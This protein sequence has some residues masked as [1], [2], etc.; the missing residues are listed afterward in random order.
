M[1]LVLLMSAFSYAKPSYGADLPN[2]T[3][4]VYVTNNTVPADGTSQTSVVL[5]LKDQAGQ[6]ISVAPNRIAFRATAGRLSESVTA[7][8]YG[9]YSSVLTA[10]TAAGI[11]Y[12]SA[13]VDGMVIAGPIRVNFRAGAAD[14]KQTVLSVNQTSL[15]ANGNSQTIIHVNLKDAYGNEVSEQAQSLQLF[16]SLGQI[17][18][19]T[20]DTYGQY[21]ASIV[22]A[23]YGELGS[24]T[25][26]VGLAGPFQ[27]EFK[28][29]V[30]P[31]SGSDGG[32]IPALLSMTYE[33]HGAYEA[34]LTAPSQPGKARITASLNGVSVSSSVYVTFG[35]DVQADT[36]TSLSFG[37]STYSSVVGQDV[38][39]QLKAEWRSGVSTD[40]S[41]Y[42][43]YS[44]ADPSMASVSPGG[45]LQA[46]K[47]GQTVL[48]ATYGGALTHAGITVT[49]A[50]NPAGDSGDSSDSGNSP[51]NSNPPSPGT[52][53]PE[54]SPSVPDS[55]S[56]ITIVSSDGKSRQ[57]AVS[58]EDMK[59]GS[60]EL[61]IDKAGGLVSIP[62]AVVQE[63]RASNQQ[64]QVTVRAGES[65]MT[66]PVQEMNPQTYSDQF[67]VPADSIQFQV[68]IGEPQPAV[69]DAIRMLSELTESK[70]LSSPV[71]FEIGVTGAQNQTA[72]ISSFNSY[73]TR[74]IGM[75]SQ[76]VPATATGVWWD[77]AA[78]EFHFVPTVFE[79]R[80]GQW[81]AVMK[82]QG[83][84]LF[85][86]IDHPV[87]FEDV[88]HHWAGDDVS[89]LASKLIVQGRGRE[90]FEPEAPI[91][92][93]E[94]AALL[95]RAMGMNEAGVEAPFRDN[96]GGWYENAVGA[97]YR[98][99]L[100][101]GYEDG[102]FRPEQQVTREEVAVMMVRAMQFAGL[103]PAAFEKRGVPFADQQSI[104]NW[105]QEKVQAA[106]AAGIVETGGDFRPGSLSTRAEAVTML[107][108]MLQSV[109]FISS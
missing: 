40:V 73:V 42:A 108:R 22:S 80:G 93:A 17:G 13:D 10:P 52:S 26:N 47:P 90:L 66:L 84:S 3:G 86:V 24:A 91:T 77:P 58:P 44:I 41:P 70:L 5:L 46:L 50:E 103:N 76:A 109:G 102:T 25:E 106:G 54:S 101:S 107:K 96:S 92:R 83:A 36:V 43:V 99:G 33:S 37:Q 7:S 100:V 59:K 55:T 97:A 35:G 18:S 34:V 62:A 39:T 89:L 4:Q 72:F 27:F 88:K 28:P 20:Y 79:Q 53:P 98:A 64:A 2:V 21:K 71:Q 32:S 16:T 78:A 57:Q 1:I 14:P 48:T 61:T 85:T 60:I 8:A 75:G 104:A 51:D 49:A 94:I 6:A 68:R 81:V 82:S 30:L 65:S 95:V 31:Y 12:V 105:A 11:A 29:G 74:T 38:S 45:V 69:S 63:I 19:V 9:E 87:T 56:S 23:V 15:P 67:H